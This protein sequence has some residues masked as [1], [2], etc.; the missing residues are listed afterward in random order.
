MLYYRNGLGW[1][2]LKPGTNGEVLSLASGLPDWIT[3]PV[4][5]AYKDADEENATTTLNGDDELTVNLAASSK[6]QF[7]AKLF[8]LNDGAAEGYKVSINGTVGV[9]DVKAQVSIYDDTLNTLVAFARIAALGGAGVGA[10]LSS[11]SNFARV[12]GAIETTTA[13]TFLI[14]FAQNAAGAAAGVH[15]EVGCSL[16]VIEV[17]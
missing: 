6:Y 9:A 16:K 13:G 5:G 3:S 7:E 10:G 8:F 17:E 2:V 4:M 1:Q 14:E 11:G 15:H 12:E